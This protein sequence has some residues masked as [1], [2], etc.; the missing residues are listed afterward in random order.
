[1][2]FMLAV[3]SRESPSAAEDMRMGTLRER[4]N[5]GKNNNCQREPIFH[6]SCK[7][8]SISAENKEFGEG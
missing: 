2:V 3:Q 4:E 6:L 7:Y 5:S 1:M 8:K